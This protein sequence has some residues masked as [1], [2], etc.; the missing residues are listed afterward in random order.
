MFVD[1]AVAVAV[2]HVLRVTADALG[3]DGD[4]RARAAS[5]ASTLRPFAA[6]RVRQLR[7]RDRPGR[8]SRSNA[9]FGLDG[10]GHVLWPRPGNCSGSLAST[11]CPSEPLGILA[12]AELFVERAPRLLEPRTPWDPSDHQVVELCTRFDGLPLAVGLAAGEVRRWSLAETAAAPTTPRTTWQ[13]AQPPPT[14]AP[15]DGRRHRLELC[16]ARRTEQR[17]LRHLAVFPSSFEL[18]ALEPLPPLLPDLDVDMVLASLV[19]KSLVVRQL[20]IGSFR[21]LETIRAFA[22]ERLAEHGEREAAF[23]HHRRWT[24]ASATAATKL[25]R[26][27]SGRLAASQRVGAAD[28]ARRSGRAS[29]RVTSTTP[30]NWPWRARSCGAT[31]SA[32]SRATAGSTRSPARTSN[33]EPRHGSPS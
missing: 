14:T 15:H 5:S 3:V 2:L 16:A 33:L 24:V 7:A 32:A 31:R 13:R 21:L 18:D 11:S 28:T 23:E 9:A 25:D 8:R 17:L 26:S 12:A 20:E 22:L 29:T 19:D 6:H 30:S 4:I 1:L 10:P 27:M